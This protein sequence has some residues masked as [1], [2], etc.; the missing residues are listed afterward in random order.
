[1]TELRSLLGRSK[2]RAMHITSWLVHLLVTTV[3]VFIVAKI[4]PGMKVKSLGSAFWFSL[5]VAFFS[6]IAWTF[7]GWLTLPFAILTLGIGMFVVNGI[8]FMA[9]GKVV[10]GVEISGCLSAIF[11]SIGVTIV[12]WGIRM[13]IPGLHH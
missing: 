7:F 3:S 11:A 6:A 12:N 13:V 2:L 5:V 4:L 10:G 8:I 1:M 9:A